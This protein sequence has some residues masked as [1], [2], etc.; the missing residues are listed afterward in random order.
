MRDP[1]LRRSVLAGAGLALTLLVA[2][3][4]TTDTA[5]DT[6]PAFYANLAK[7]GKPVDVAAAASL[8][9][10]Y[11]TGRGLSPLT[12]DEQLNK[13]AQDQANAMARADNLSHE[14]GG[15][16]FMTRIKASGYNAS[17]AVENVGA[18]YHTLAEA[19]SGWRDSPSHNKNMLEAGVSRMGIATANA[20][21]SKY[22]VYWALVLAQPDSAGR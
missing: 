4:G 3:C 13:I 6:Q 22:K 16:N 18:G 19:F 15:R 11:R 7:T 14:V 1:I 9:S 20:P 10:D 17:K 5:L 2:G 12:P 21:N 8:L